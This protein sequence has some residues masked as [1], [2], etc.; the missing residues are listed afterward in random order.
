MDAENERTEKIFEST[1]LVKIKYR[2]NSSWQGSVQWVEAG[3]TQ[4]F[5]SCL[6]LMRL[7]DTA[8]GAEAETDKRT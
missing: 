6:E 4:N 2:Q 5:K 1:F 3:K 7:M 8:V